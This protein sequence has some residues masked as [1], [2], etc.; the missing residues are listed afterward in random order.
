MNN[1]NHGGVKLET[2]I[3]PIPAGK[4]RGWQVLLNGKEVK[5][6]Q[7]VQI[8]SKY[9][10]LSYGLT[11]GGYDG[12]SFHEAGG[13][14]SV[15]VPY[16]YTGDKQLFIGLY[17]EERPN[18]GGRVL[19][20]PRGFID[21]GETHFQCAARELTEEFGSIMDVAKRV[22]KL[23]GLPTNPNSAFFETWGSG[24][25]VHFHAIQILEDEVVVG[26]AGI[27]LKMKA[28]LGTDAATHIK[29][30]SKIANAIACS[31][32]IPWREA[33][34]LGDAFTQCGIA[35]LVATDLKFL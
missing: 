27:F 7:S 33:V 21:P 18:Q 19:N 10:L 14:G 28:Q 32:F 30:S 26:T 3:K 13:G 20:V 11:P 34:A 24:E 9:G 17:E 31:Q 2:L 22:F 29:A 8:K 16:L 25:G 15:T 6:V 1:S 4:N 35:R 5:D 12:W 23:P